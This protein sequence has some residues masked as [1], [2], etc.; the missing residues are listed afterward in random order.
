MK[1]IT[2]PNERLEVTIQNGAILIRRFNSEPPVTAQAIPER[3]QTKQ[4]LLRRLRVSPRRADRFRASLNEQQIKAL[5][6]LLD[7][8]LIIRYR[9]ISGNQSRPYYRLCNA[10][11]SNQESTNH[12]Y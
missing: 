4:D 3:D 11:T 8:A 6:E 9:Q 2:A 7:D 5:N 10:L 1:I 12:E